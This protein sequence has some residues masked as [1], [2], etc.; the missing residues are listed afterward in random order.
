M[1]PYRIRKFKGGISSRH[2][3]G[4]PG[5]FKMGRNLEIR[6]ANDSLSCKQAL[7][8]IG[9]VIQ[10]A[11]A[12][13]SPSA[14][15]SPS[16]SLSPSISPSQ[17]P[18]AS[19]SPSI[20]SSPSAS[21][22]PSSSRSP[23]ASVS[24]SASTS[25]SHSNSP[26]AS[27]SAGL[28]TVFADLILWWVK[29]S[30]GYTYGFGDTGK[31]YR[32][33]TDFDCKLVYDLHERITG[34]IEKPTKNGQTFLMFAG[35]TTLHIKEIPGR[36]DWNDIDQGLPDYPRTNLSAQLWHTMKVVAGDVA[37]A[38][39]SQLAMVFYSDNSYTNE[40]V[41][42]IP[43]NITKTI[44]ERVGRSVAGTYRASDPDKGINAAIDA[45]QPLAQVG[46]DGGLFFANLIDS[47]P[48][49]RFPGGGKVN[50][51][52]VCNE[53]DQVNFFEWEVTALSWISKQSVGNM[54]LWGVYGADS[55]YNGIYSYGRKSKDENTALNLDY[56]MDV[57]EIGAIES[58]NGIVYASYRDGTDYGV[59]VTDVN[60]KA[61]AE[62]EGLEWNVPIKTPEKVTAWGN[63][64]VFMYP[65]P[66][67]CAVQFLYKMN[68]YGDFIIART[69]DKDSQASFAKQG[70]QKA[71][72]QIGAVGDI[73]EPKVILIPSG[74]ATPEAYRIISYFD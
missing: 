17:S 25:P 37:I 15:R 1:S 38:N 11:S 43:G 48:A 7:M 61:I 55:G 56:A 63:V 59:K 12:S 18:S 30:D 67:G 3:E 39:G 32:I 58:V 45:E 70:A 53:L 69:A 44:V 26:S 14:S 62:Y 21:R 66:A 9:N 72:F 47:V 6:K 49:L 73:Y 4:Q 16:A 41:D 22:S 20:G 35:R 28:K 68:K 52:G 27:P 51:G 36:A 5:A 23:S 57:D 71:T 31:I 29:C 8:D 65:L 10:S 60:N 64:E 40:A 50:P 2:D 46:N 24:I 34:A 19:T 74:N 13:P 54:S 42:Y 33:G